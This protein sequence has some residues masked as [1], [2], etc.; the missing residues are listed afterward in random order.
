MVWVTPGAGHLDVFLRLCEEGRVRAGLVG[1]AY[2]A[3][4]ALD[5]GCEVVTLDTD[6]A[7]FPG[8]RWRHPSV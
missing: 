5:Q 6:F 8:L 1:D 7:R 3:A 4:V 2:V